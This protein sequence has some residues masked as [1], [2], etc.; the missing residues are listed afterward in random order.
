MTSILISNVMETTLQHWNIYRGCATLWPS[1]VAINKGAEEYLLVGVKFDSSVKDSRTDVN[2][3]NKA[4]TINDSKNM[5]NL[6]R[7]S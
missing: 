5:N 7:S 1:S 4:Y 2:D 6:T 3:P